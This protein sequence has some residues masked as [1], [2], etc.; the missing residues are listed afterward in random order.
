MDLQD[1]RVVW[2]H[3]VSDYKPGYSAI[4]LIPLLISSKCTGGA[5]SQ[6]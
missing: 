2:V 3:G 1:Y 6:L 5:C 4:S